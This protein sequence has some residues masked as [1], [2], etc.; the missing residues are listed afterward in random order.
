MGNEILRRGDMTEAE[1]LAG[2][3]VQAR[4]DD[5]SERARGD[6][7]IRVLDS[8]ACAIGA[9][10]AEPVLM[11]RAQIDDFGGSPLCGLIGGGRSAPDRAAFYNGALVR[12]LD[13]MDSYFAKGE[14]CH[15]S[16]N[17]APV[18]AAA[19]YAG[20][21]GRTFLTALAVAYQVQTRLSDAAPVRDRGFDHTAQGAYAVG[22]GVARALGLDAARTAHAIALSG[23]GNI[24]LRVTRTG[25]LSHWKGLAYPNTAF[26]GLHGAFLAMRGVTG[27][28]EVF[29][30]DKGFMQAVS[31]PYT[32]DWAKEDLERVTRTVIK[33]YNA[34]AH[35]QS[36]IAGALEL[37]ARHDLK[38]PEIS[39]V[40]IEMFDVAHRIIGGGEEG[41]K[42]IVRT[43]E[44]ADHS[45]PYMVAAALCDGELMPAQYA[46]D[47]IGQPDV[48]DLLRRIT[49]TPSADF[50]ARFPEELACRVVI[51][52]RDGRRFDIEAR[53][54]EGFHTRPASFQTV[55]RKFHELAAPF[56]GDDLRKEIVDAVASLETLRLR[57]LTAILDKVPRER[58]QRAGPAPDKQGSFP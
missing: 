35:A 36:V 27:P 1:K 3:V 8:L 57:D 14:T 15:P 58:Q 50:S 20:A 46:P 51:T 5:L 54:Y 12:Y 28:L 45:L 38:E 18:L 4:Y 55:T 44:Q 52:L 11:V 40:D 7:K 19:D 9:L 32:I 43:K 30:G 49:I 13:F 10:D 33:A 17:L 39:H 34:E 24:A 25:L 37:R 31:G 56:A 2:F 41:D 48:Q 47:R 21:D 42:T 23:V 22:A 29:E 53:D 26:I 16:D 6:L